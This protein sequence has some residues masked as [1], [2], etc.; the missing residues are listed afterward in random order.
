[1]SPGQIVPLQCHNMGDN[2]HEINMYGVLMICMD[3]LHVWGN[4]T[5]AFSVLLHRHLAS[6]SL[7]LQILYNTYLTYFINHLYYIVNMYQIHPLRYDN[8]FSSLNGLGK[9]P[10]YERSIFDRR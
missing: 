10:N 8:Y 1:M 7:E 9:Y 4:L 6:C 2:G 3:N 5:G